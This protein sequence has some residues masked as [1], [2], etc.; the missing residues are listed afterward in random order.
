[1]RAG[2]RAH[3][4]MVAQAQPPVVVVLAGADGRAPAQQ[5][6]VRVELRAAR[7]VRAAVAVQAELVEAADRQLQLIAAVQL[8]Q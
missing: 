8:Q 3:P 5:A 2:V 7:A 6:R 1:M 4:V